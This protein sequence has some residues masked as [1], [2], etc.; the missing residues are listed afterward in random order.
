[1]ATTQT[2]TSET[3]KVQMGNE[4]E[5]VF[6]KMRNVLNSIQ[7]SAGLINYRIREFHV[8][9]V[10]RVVDMLEAHSHDY[11]WYL[12]QDPKGKKIPYGPNVCA[13]SECELSF[14][15]GVLSVRG[16]RAIWRCQPAESRGAPTERQF[17]SGPACP[18]GPTPNGA[19][20]GVGGRLAAHPVLR[21]SHAR[22]EAL[23]A[24]EG[25]D[26]ARAVQREVRC[27]LALLQPRADAARTS[28]GRSEILAALAELK[29]GQ[30]ELRLV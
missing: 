28:G 6:H 9:D 19:S 25:D 2:A 15:N 22:L 3:V 30:Q 1:M 10:G 13:G 27:H 23:R 14:R 8:E 12:T 5:S 17:Q 21:K 16:T 18:S 29:A 20:P 24:A 4:G 26:T 7:V 11:G